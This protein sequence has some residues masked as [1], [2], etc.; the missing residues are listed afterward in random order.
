MATSPR[1]G[2]IQV[3]FNRTRK[4]QGPRL[5]EDGSLESSPVDGGSFA[6]RSEAFARPS[7]S[8]W[9]M[10][11]LVVIVLMAAAFY[12]GLRASDLRKSN[13]SNAGVQESSDPLK[14][15][16]AAF[17]SGNHLAAATQFAAI[18]ERDPQNAEAHYWLGRAQVELNE[19]A[20]AILNFD[21]AVALRP[22]LYDA[23]AYQAAA[24]EA[25]GDKAKAAQTLSRYAEERRKQPAQ[26]LDN[27]NTSLR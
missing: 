25:V 26:R 7:Q 24:Y 6:E 20:K 2:R 19:Y 22:S 27:S 3:D 5:P 23:Y 13:A 4:S 14:A 11:A 9:L 8:R 15:G 10:W 12:A 16:R 21:H 17:D 18:V 1:G